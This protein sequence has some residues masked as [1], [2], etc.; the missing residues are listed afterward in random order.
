MKT[1]GIVVG[2]GWVGVCTLLGLWSLMVQGPYAAGFVLTMAGSGY[3]LARWAAREETLRPV[4]AVEVATR[5]ASKD[6]KAG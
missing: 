5:S 3:V 2:R 1:V 4:P 6:Q